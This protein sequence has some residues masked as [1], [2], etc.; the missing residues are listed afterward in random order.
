M[1]KYNIF[2]WISLIAVIFPISR[3]PLPG[4][5][6]GGG[7]VSGSVRGCSLGESVRGGCKGGG[8]GLPD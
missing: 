4:G 6:K 1:A 5:C 2:F 8:G 7:G 3:R